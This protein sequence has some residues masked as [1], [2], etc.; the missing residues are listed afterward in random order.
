MRYV[1]YGRA[2]R[3][4]LTGAFTPFAV[5]ADLPGVQA[6]R[7]APLP[8]GPISA[9]GH[10]PPFK[11]QAPFLDL[12]VLRAVLGVPAVAP[13]GPQV[14]RGS[15]QQLLQALGT[16]PVR[17]QGLWGGGVAAAPCQGRLAHGDE[18]LDDSPREVCCGVSLLKVELRVGIDLAR[19]WERRGCEP[20]DPGGDSSLRF[21]SILVP[22]FAHR[23]SPPFSLPSKLLGPS[24]PCPHL[25]V[26]ASRDSRV[27]RL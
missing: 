6:P 5:A 3:L 7:V 24:L 13:L 2:P 27:R 1:S 21:A 10:G 16:R 14:R 8:S 26:R 20:R 4:L 19:I 12:D 18:E 11:A 9:L 22:R 25:P 17:V 23:S 15:R